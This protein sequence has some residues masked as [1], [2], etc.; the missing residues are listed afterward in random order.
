M[1]GTRCCTRIGSS[2]ESIMTQRVWKTGGK[3]DREVQPQPGGRGD[4]KPGK[5]GWGDREQSDGQ[6][7]AGRPGG[8][9][10]SLDACFSFM[11]ATDR[12]Q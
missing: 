12:G 11:T 2:E 1:G 8:L 3:S 7:R 9:A 5:S 10:G 4:A 6:G